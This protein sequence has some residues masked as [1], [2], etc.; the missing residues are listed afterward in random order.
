MPPT[1]CG[2]QQSE[3]HK[4]MQS[5]IFSI[6]CAFFHDIYS[7]NFIC[8]LGFPNFL[9]TFFLLLSV[10]IEGNE[11]FLKSGKYPVL[12]ILSAG[13]ALHVFV[14]GQLSGRQHIAGFRAF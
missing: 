4:T 9:Y 5:L 10:K 2:T 1:I 8:N 12:S 13:H 14:N 7:Q 3:C 6:F 11:E